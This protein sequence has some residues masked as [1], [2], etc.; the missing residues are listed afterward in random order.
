MAICMENRLLNMIIGYYEVP[1]YL[2]I[3]V[4]TK[5]HAHSMHFAMNCLLCVVLKSDHV[6]KWIRNT[7][8]VLKHDTGVGWRRRLDRSCEK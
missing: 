5:C 7:L 2:F 3:R 1:T 4:T 8:E 6:V